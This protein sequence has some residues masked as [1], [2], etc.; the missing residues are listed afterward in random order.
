MRR[1][2]YNATVASMDGNMNAYQAIGTDGIKI[3]FLGSSADAE[4]QSWDEKRNMNGAMILPGFNDTHMHM[5]YYATFS[6]SVMLFGVDSIDGMVG[7]LRKRTTFLCNRCGLEPG[8]HEGRP[9]Y[10]KGRP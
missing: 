9:P 2:W 7:R 10:Y 5:L 1:L 3:V 4:R 8:V 6:R